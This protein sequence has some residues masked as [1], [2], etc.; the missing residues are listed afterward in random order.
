MESVIND[1][2]DQ[3]MEPL[4]RGKLTQVVQ[5]V[6]TDGND[7]ED[8][9][10]AAMISER[11][12]APPQPGAALFESRNNSN[13][14]SLSIDKSRDEPS[15]TARSGHDKLIA[16]GIKNDSGETPPD[17]SKIEVGYE[18]EAEAANSSAD[19]DAL[20]DAVEKIIHP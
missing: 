20:I 13:S 18:D 6:E 11:A 3:T 4:Q 5:H 17:I 9:Q 16:L 1:P 7:L 12:L 19:E 8:K 15:M 10:P 2:F 14:E